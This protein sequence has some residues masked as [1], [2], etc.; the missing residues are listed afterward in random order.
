MSRLWLLCVADH[1]YKVD[2]SSA[3]RPA[4]LA[5]AAIAASGFEALDPVVVGR[6][7]KREASS[8]F[9]RHITMSV[10]WGS[11]MMDIYGASP[12]EQAS[13]CQEQWK[14]ELQ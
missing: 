14:Q 12:G 8:R 3:F 6:Q 7:A 13:I 10:A 1:G 2:E 4:Q 9:F 11:F 5:R